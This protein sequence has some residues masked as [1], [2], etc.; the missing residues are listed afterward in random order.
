M[1]NL[2]DPNEIRPHGWLKDQ[3]KIQAE[4]L[5]GNLD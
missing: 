5:Y 1:Y 2:F 4:G 3:L